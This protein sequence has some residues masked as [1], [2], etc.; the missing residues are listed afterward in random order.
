MLATATNAVTVKE[1]PTTVTAIAKDNDAHAK[2]QRELFAAA[3]TITTS[4]PIAANATAISHPTAANATAPITMMAELRELVAAT[5]ALAAANV[6]KIDAYAKANQ[7]L[8]AANAMATTH[9][10][11]ANAMATSH[12]IAA[13]AT[14]FSHP[15]VAVSKENNIPPSHGTR[16]GHDYATGGIV[17]AVNSPGPSGVASTAVLSLPACVITSWPGIA[18]SVQIPLSTTAWMSLRT[19][20][21]LS[22]NVAT[23]TQRIEKVC[24]RQDAHLEAFMAGFRSFAEDLDQRQPLMSASFA[25]INDDVDDDRDEDILSIDDADVDFEDIT[26]VLTPPPPLPY[27]GMVVP[28]LGGEC[29]LS[30]PNL[31]SASEL[32]TAPPQKMACRLKWP[33]RRPCC[34]N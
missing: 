30:P 34:R 23:A 1:I 32:A 4:P 6:T 5:Q 13:N 10:I 17:L 7:G 31:L 12:P 29:P 28:F 8:F 26:I 18:P 21:G 33:C 14:A 25:S 11:A 22:D 15:T 3:N 20:A 9:P 16:D 27:T 19:A 2:A 24:T